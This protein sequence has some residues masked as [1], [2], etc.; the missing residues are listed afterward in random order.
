V[1]PEQFVAWAEAAFGKYLPLMKAEVSRWLQPHE[2]WFIAGMRMVALEGHPSV[3]G[4][5]PGVYELEQFKIKAF[6]KGHTLEAIASANKSTRLLDTDVAEDFVTPEEGERL[7][8]ELRA[9][10]D[11][12][13]RGKT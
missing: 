12:M 4:K 11:E 10:M 3:Y 2:S 9:R 5:P 13:A 8:A 1:T 6:E 7:F